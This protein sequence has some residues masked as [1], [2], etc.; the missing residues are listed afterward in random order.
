M[1]SQ[2]KWGKTAD[3]SGYGVTRCTCMEIA[4]PFS[5]AGETWVGGR[6]RASTLGMFWATFVFELPAAVGASVA[7]FAKKDLAK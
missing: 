4:C 5:H 1:L 7:G 2:R 3:S 6:S